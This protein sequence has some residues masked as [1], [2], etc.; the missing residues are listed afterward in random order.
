MKIMFLLIGVSL[1]MAIGFLLAFVWTVKSGQME[2]DY[3]PS[4]RILFD[5]KPVAVDENITSK[6]AE[7]FKSDKNQF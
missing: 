7:N 6:S 4:V 3:T 5:D 1:F 2:D